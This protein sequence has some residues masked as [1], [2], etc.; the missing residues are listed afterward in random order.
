MK[1]AISIQSQ[2]AECF[3]LIWAFGQL[4]KGVYNTEQIWKKVRNKGLKCSKVQTLIDRG[5]VK[6]VAIKDALNH[7]NLTEIRADIG[8][9]FPEKVVYDESKVR[10]ARKN[11]FIQC[12]NLINKSYA[13]I[14]TGQK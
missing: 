12:I 10:T 9:I 5:I 11:E 1:Q 4:A 6:I 2:T 3:R 7:I 14:K 8:S 13:K